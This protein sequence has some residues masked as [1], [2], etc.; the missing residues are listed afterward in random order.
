M[1]EFNVFVLAHNVS[2]PCTAAGE[3]RGAGA[4]AGGARGTGGCLFTIVVEN[5]FVMRVVIYVGMVTEFND[6]YDFNFLSA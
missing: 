2:S 5:V 1:I 3:A 4:A 6:E